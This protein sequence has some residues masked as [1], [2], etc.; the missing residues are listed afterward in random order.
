MVDFED[1]LGSY[2]GIPLCTKNDVIVLNNCGF[3]VILW[4]SGDDTK[5]QVE[6]WIESELRFKH[7]QQITVLS[8]RPSNSLLWLLQFLKISISVPETN[9]FYCSLFPGVRLSKNPKRIIRMHDPFGLKS[10]WLGAFLNGGGK[11]KLRFARALRTKALMNVIQESTMLFN[12]EYTLKRCKSLY[13]YQ[14]GSVIHSLVQFSDSLDLGRSINDSPYFLIIGGSRQRKKPE[15]VVNLWASS[16]LKESFELVV[17]GKIPLNLLSQ[18]SK[19]QIASRRLRIIH[20]INSAELQFLVNHCV[21]TFF[22]SLGEGWGQPLAESVYCGKPV[23]C[24]DLEVF[25]EVA[26]GYASFF[27]TNSPNELI[28]LAKSLY[29]MHIERRINETEISRF[30]ERYGLE[31]LKTKWQELLC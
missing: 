2:T 29:K 27:P 13:G 17:V 11:L 8:T 28:P 25:K 12:S 23:I 5:R 26:N 19:E 1:V 31:N 15:I 4:V 21:A 16:E 14:R 22:Y 10:D 30:G 7:P 24:N 20:G 6:N 3:Q 18:E 9:Y